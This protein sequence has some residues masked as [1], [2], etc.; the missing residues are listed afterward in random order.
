MPPEVSSEVEYSPELQRLLARSAQINSYFG[1]DFDVSFSSL[2]LAFLASDDFVSQWFQAYV[3]KAGVDV[4]TILEARK[5]SREIMEE[6]TAA[7]GRLLAWSRRRASPVSFSQLP[8]QKA[9]IRSS[10][11]GYPG[12]RALLKYWFLDSIFRLW[13]NWWN[14]RL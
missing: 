10:E 11:V 9:W 4:G 3:K 1:E 7:N 2:L 14:Q 13:R 8:E 12:P 6:I 5:L